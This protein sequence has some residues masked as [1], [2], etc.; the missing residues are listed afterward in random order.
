MRPASTPWDGWASFSPRTVF[1]LHPKCPAV[2]ALLKVTFYTEV[3]VGPLSSPQLMPGTYCWPVSLRG[4]V[5]PRQLQG[6]GVALSHSASLAD[7]CSA[8][9]P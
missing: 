8:Q 3:H 9:L 5:L 4:G 7:P 2:S 1:T 6:R